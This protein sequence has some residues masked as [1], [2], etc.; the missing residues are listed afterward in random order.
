MADAPASGNE[1]EAPGQ[2]AMLPDGGVMVYQ[3][4]SQFCRCC[5][6]QPNIDWTIHP[7]KDDWAHTDQLETLMTIKEDAPYFGRCMSNPCPA[8]RSTKYTVH[9]G[10]SEQGHVLFTHQKSCTNSNCPV[11]MYGQGG[12]VRCPCCCALPYLDTLDEN[13]K[14]IGTT[15][16]ICDMWCFVP[17]YSVSDASGDVVY[18]IRPETCVAGCCVNCKCNG[19]KGKC[20]RIP[21]LIRDPKPPHAPLKDAVITDLWAGGLNECCANREMYSLKFPAPLQQNAK[22]AE[23][24]R[25]TLV[26]S[27]LL[28]DM[29]LN[30]QDL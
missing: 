22:L 13:G 6:C 16:Y 26:G 28:I 1:V 8:A 4:T 17:K 19:Q 24:M 14:T 10:D 15:K 12:P 2:M 27:T 7:Y 30:E 20:F 23:N 25:K 29:S 9:R 21:F 5:C 11:V 3:K 18:L